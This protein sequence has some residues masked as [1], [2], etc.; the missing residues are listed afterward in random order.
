[1]QKLMKY[2]SPTRRHIYF[3]IYWLYVL[4]Y[5]YYLNPINQYL[6]SH[7]ESAIKIHPIK[8]SKSQHRCISNILHNFSQSSFSADVSYIQLIM[9]HFC[10]KW[11]FW[12]GVQN[13]QNALILWFRDFSNNFLFCFLTMIKLGFR[14][15]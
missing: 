5:S 9:R 7:L 1:M 15:S 14:L 4:K 8:V 12:K 6:H 13:I 11:R 3:T 2:I 10:R